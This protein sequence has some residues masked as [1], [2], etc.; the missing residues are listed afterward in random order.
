MLCIYIYILL[1]IGGVIP[2]VEVFKIGF[3]YIVS[4]R[5]FFIKGLTN[6]HVLRRSLPVINGSA[7]N[8]NKRI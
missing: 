7:K 5:S 6:L 4:L 8:V 2:F 1:F 3:V